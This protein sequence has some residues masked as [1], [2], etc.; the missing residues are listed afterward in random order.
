MPR[1]KAKGDDQLLNPPE[2]VLALP[3]PRVSHRHA[4][5]EDPYESPPGAVVVV[6]SSV[7]KRPQTPL[8]ATRRTVARKD[9]QMRGNRYER[10]LLL[11]Q[12]YEG[13]Q[14]KALAEV[15][16][17]EPGEVRLRLRELHADV[18]SGIGSSSLSSILEAQDLSMTARAS[19]LRKHAYSENP[20][21]SLKAIQMVGEFEGARSDTGSFEE[22]LRLARSQKD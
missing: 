1:R 11:M 4:H 7:P 9:Q 16:G 14:V 8:D 17:L 2:A 13:D 19:L 21:A 3:A 5:A 6:S 15:Y 20:A 10:Y 18:K 22:Y 12:E